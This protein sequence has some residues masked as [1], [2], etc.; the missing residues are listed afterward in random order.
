MLQSAAIHSF[1]QSPAVL[2]LGKITLANYRNYGELSLTFDPSPVILTGQ[3]G[4]GKTNLLEAIS[5]L[6]P[7]R[8]L[9]RAAL[10]ELQNQH[11]ADP[12]AVATEISTPF[13]PIQIG[14]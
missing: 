2:S 14:T 4:S 12:W 6:V 9:R 13:G 1:N 11:A 7:G 3:N 8:G 5:L 10:G